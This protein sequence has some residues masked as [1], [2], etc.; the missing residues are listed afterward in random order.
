MKK[1][2]KIGK[3]ILVYCLMILGITKVN[4]VTIGPPSTVTQL[5]SSENNVYSYD[6]GIDFKQWILPAENEDE[7][8]YCLID[9]WEIGELEKGE[10]KTIYSVDISSAEFENLYSIEVKSGET[11]TFATRVFVENED[12]G[13][14]YSSYSSAVVLDHRP[15][16]TIYTKIANGEGCFTISGEGINEQICGSKNEE[17]KTYQV[18]SGTKVTVK[19]TP[20]QGFSFDGWYVFDTESD[21]ISVVV[22]STE[23][24]YSFTAEALDDEYYESIAPAFIENY[25]AK[26]NV[27]KGAN[28]K[29]VSEESAEFEIDA[30]YSLFEEGGKVYIDDDTNPLNPSNYTSKAGST[31]I[32]LTKEYINTLSV[33]EHTLKVVFNDGNEATTAFTV[34]KNS[35]N[36]ETD[37]KI[38]IPNT[39]INSSKNILFYLFVIILS[40]LGL[41]ERIRKTKNKE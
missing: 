5:K 33:G 19:A 31:I 16:A 29:V 35:S 40:I 18:P 30:D 10:Y 26:Y 28:Q 11:K 38:E 37:E 22:Q 12:G 4:A 36:T 39:G 6:I 32:T 17:R 23:L 3:Y 7:V 15:L 25:K 9:G 24:E 27:I 41:C 14:T 1:Y 20:N 2:L 34:T 21:L 13:Y 8:P